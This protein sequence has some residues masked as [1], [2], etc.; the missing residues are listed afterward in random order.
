[1]KEKGE[2]VPCGTEDVLTTALQTPEHSGR[3]RGVGGFV[4]PTA[5]FNLPKAKKTKITKAELLEELERNRR[6]MAE[7]KALISASNSHSPM[8]SDKSSCQPVKEGAVVKP[9]SAKQL[10]VNDDEDCVACEPPP[11]SGQKVKF[12]LIE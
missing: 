12:L 6:E 1:M 5:F 9:P 11:S 4:T 8:F 3:V 7:L 2:F 10:L